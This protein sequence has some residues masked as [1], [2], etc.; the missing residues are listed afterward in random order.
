MLM[1]LALIPQWNKKGYNVTFKSGIHVT[2]KNHLIFYLKQRMRVVYCKD[3]CTEQG[4]G[5]IMLHSL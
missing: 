2:E 4:I 5:Q 1:K 3:W